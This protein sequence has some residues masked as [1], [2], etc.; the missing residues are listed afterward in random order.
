MRFSP[1]LSAFLSS[2]FD[3]G[4]PPHFFASRRAF[5]ISEEILCQ[6]R[7]TILTRTPEPDTDVHLRV[8]FLS[9]LGIVP[10]PSH[11][12]LPGLHRCVPS[13]AVM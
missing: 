6:A 3:S 8:V 4:S 9:W 13:F 5:S 11:V 2:R 10:D 1:P 7:N 12:P